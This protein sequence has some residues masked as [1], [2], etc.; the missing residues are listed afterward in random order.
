MCLRPTPRLELLQQ[1]LRSVP[2][3]FNS[4]PN[5]RVDPETLSVRSTLCK[6]HSCSWVLD[7][8]VVGLTLYSETKPNTRFCVLF[9]SK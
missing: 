3:V 5:T 8:I 6:T 7:L 4:P 1:E 9:R 2:Q